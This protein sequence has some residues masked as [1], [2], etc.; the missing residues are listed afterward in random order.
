MVPFKVDDQFIVH[1]K[2]PEHL[3]VENT[4]KDPRV[5]KRFSIFLEKK[6]KHATV[7]SVKIAQAQKSIL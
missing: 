1:V 3:S 6:Q 5:E 4:K 2:V 7:F